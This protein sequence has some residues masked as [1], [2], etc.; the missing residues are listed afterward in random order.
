MLATDQTLSPSADADRDYKGPRTFRFR[1]I[2]YKICTA[3]ECCH[4]SDSDLR[5]WIP[6]KVPFRKLGYLYAVMPYRALSHAQRRKFFPLK[7]YE[8]RWGHR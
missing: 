3:V 5:Y 1:G 2:R 7:E 4:R 8:A 6:V